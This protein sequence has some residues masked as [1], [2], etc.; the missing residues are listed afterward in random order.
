MDAG[1]QQQEKQAAQVHV[2]NRPVICDKALCSLRDGSLW[3]QA[4]ERDGVGSM[5]QYPCDGDGLGDHGTATFPK[6]AKDLTSTDVN[7]GLCRVD[8]PSFRKMRPI[9]N[10]RSRPPT[11][12]TVRLH[13]HRRGAWQ[14]DKGCHCATHMLITYIHGAVEVHKKYIKPCMMT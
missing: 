11:W 6:L 8:T 13:S 1:G 3:N 9:S 2:H 4:N 5:P 12:S 14:F 7:S 10:T